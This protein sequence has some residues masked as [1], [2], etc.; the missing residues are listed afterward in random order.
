VICEKPLVGSLADVDRGD[1]RGAERSK[2]M[3]M[4]VFQYR[5]GNGIEQVKAIIDAGIAG[6]PY[7]G[8]VETL[9]R[10]ETPIIMPCRGA[11]NGRPNSV[12][13]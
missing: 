4:P 6:K 10:R 12:A 8:T 9:W 5:F 2:G 3:L 13:C 11:A 1:C 7:V